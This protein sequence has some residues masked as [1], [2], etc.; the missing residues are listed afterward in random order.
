MK[1]NYDRQMMDLLETI[2]CRPRLLLHACCAPCATAVTERLL[3]HFE[4][5]LYYY[6]PNIAPEEEYVKRGDEIIRLGQILGVKT[7][8][9]AYEPACFYDA[10]RGLEN[11]REGGARCPACFSLRLE[12]TARLAREMGISWFCTTLTV[13][14]HKNP[15][16]INAI[17]QRLSGEGLSW[18]PADFKKREGYKR[19]IEMCREHDIYRQNYCGCTFSLEQSRSAL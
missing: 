2:S 13:S 9:P 4:P 5:I 17:G 11:E 10:A 3:P 12:E 7:I 15:D 6:N 8:V 1:I 14:P 16:M 18:L 19:S